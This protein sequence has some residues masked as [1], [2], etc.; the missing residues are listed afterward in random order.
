MNRSATAPN[1]ATLSADVTK[2]ETAD[3]TDIF[4]PPPSSTTALEDDDEEEEEEDDDD[5]DGTT[6][7]GDDDWSE[8][9]VRQPKLPKGKKLLDAVV[10]CDVDSLYKSVFGNETFFEI[11][12]AQAY[13]EFRHFRCSPWNRDRTSGLLERTVR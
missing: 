12:G 5:L 8:A 6:S 7:F 3:S 11:V 1:G 10:S 13:E 4:L 9:E 2:S